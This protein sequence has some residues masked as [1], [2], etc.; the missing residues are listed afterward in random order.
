MFIKIYEYN[1]T[2]KLN[3]EYFKM[4]SGATRLNRIN[5]KY[6]SVHCIKKLKYGNDT[7]KILNGSTNRQPN[8][9]ASKKSNRV[10]YVRL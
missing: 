6:K 7:T 3:D 9:W 1:D 8:T 10:C 2:G 4:M 5:L